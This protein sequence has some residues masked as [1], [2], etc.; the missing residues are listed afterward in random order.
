MFVN[1]SFINSSFV[2]EQKNLLTILAS[3]QPICTKR[4]T[5]DA[6][7]TILFHVGHKELV[8]KSTDLEISLQSSYVLKDSSV[9]HPRSFLVSGRRIFELVKELDG[10]IHFTLEEA[11]LTLQAGPVHLSLNIKDPDEFPPFPERIEN[12]MQLDAA[13]LLGMLNRVAFIIPQNNANTALN[14][15][16]LEISADEF[17]MT[18]TDGH[19]LAQVRSHAYTLPE[20]SSWLLPRRAVFEVKKILESVAKDAPIFLGTCANQLVFSG[21]SFNFFTRLLGDTFPQYAGILKRDSFAPALLDRSHFIKTLRRSACLLS[22]QFIPT[23]FKFT[24]ASLKVSMHNKDVGRLEEEVPLRDFAGDSV[25]VRFYAP[26]L[27]NGMQTFAEDAVH[28]YLQNSSKP[29]IF[30]SQVDRYSV[31]YLVMPI[32]PNHVAQANGK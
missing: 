24:P 19:C 10:D 30:E 15:L 9:Q 16:F 21:D 3:M 5:L 25:D 26:Y 20:T 32:A 1:S 7:S 31:L 6:T 8:L 13:F 14:G 29:I 28:F 11:Q 4:T 2:V 18:A 27:L 22:G 12:R 23:Q 17:K